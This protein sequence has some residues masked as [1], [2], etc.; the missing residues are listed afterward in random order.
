MWNEQG[1]ARAGSGKTPVGREVRVR[2]H[3]PARL[4]LEPVGGHVL[5]PH[6]RVDAWQVRSREAIPEHEV[7]ERA[8]NRDQ[9]LLT[10]RVVIEEHEPELPLALV[11]EALRQVERRRVLPPVLGGVLLGADLLDPL[12]VV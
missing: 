2:A 10:R 6:D 12:V 1:S 11:V 9:R 3:V 8:A 4:V 5:A 7:D